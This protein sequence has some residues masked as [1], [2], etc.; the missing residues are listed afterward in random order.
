MSPR[1]SF[2]V[3][4]VVSA[5][6]GA[7]APARLALPSGSGTPVSD[8]AEAFSSATATCRGI[9]SLTAELGLSG[10][11]G[12]QRLRGTVLAGFGSDA[13]RLEGVAPFGAPVFILVGV[14]DRGTLLL[15]RDRRVLDGAAPGEILKA[16]I[17]VDLSP[18][19]LLAAITGCVKAD[20]APLS[21]R[22][23]GSEWLV[24]DL[25]GGGMA[26][27]H[28]EG[29]EWR[30]A[31]TRIGSADFHEWCARVRGRRRSPRSTSNCACASFSRTPRFPRTRSKS[32]SPRARRRSRLKR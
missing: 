16:L 4:L 6:A 14:K 5:C 2:A 1:W 11:A 19:D 24:V 15:P 17:G 22:S 32:W 3:C 27:L 20:A 12:Q 28:R 30:V 26:Y 29:A 8:F 31:G 10:R 13:V 9:K 25:T 18:G 7:C 21:A 23:Y